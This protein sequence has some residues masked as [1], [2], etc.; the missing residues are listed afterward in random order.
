MND[1]MRET[2]TSEQNETVTIVWTVVGNSYRFGQWHIEVYRYELGGDKGQEGIGYVFGSE[3]CK[4]EQV[5]KFLNM[6]LRG[7][8]TTTP[9]RRA[10]KLIRQCETAMYAHEHRGRSAAA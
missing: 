6:V 5:A 2:M 7:C 1:H 4:T 10:N 3:T 9:T 8:G